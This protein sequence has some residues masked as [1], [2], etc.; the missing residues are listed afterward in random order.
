MGPDIIKL[1]DIKPA[2]SGYIR[3]S[4]EL[5]GQSPVPDDRAVHDIRVLMKK[6]RAV[7]TLINTLVEAKS[8]NTEYLTFLK[9]GRMISFLRDTSVYRKVLRELKKDHPGVFKRLAG[10]AGIETLMN[11]NGIQS[12]VSEKLKNDIQEVKD[13]LHRSSY[14]I[15][16]M[17]LVDLNPEILFSELQKSYLVSADKYLIARNNLKPSDIHEFRKRSKDFLYQLWFF[18]PLNSQA[19]KSLE[20]K[21]DVMTQNLGKYND[22]AQLIKYLGYKY[23]HETENPALDELVL[24]L[25]QM[26]DRY[27]SRVWPVA[28]KIFRPGRQLESIMG[29]KVLRL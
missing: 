11:S 15:R 25:R 3:E 29:F 9:A 24:L 22:L 4:L 6:S 7:M 10:A 14:R 20:K 19:V 1:K 23:P 17:T 18:R 16:F 13:M 2:L 21:L 12:T 5:I 28:Y 8:F 27:L 26:Q